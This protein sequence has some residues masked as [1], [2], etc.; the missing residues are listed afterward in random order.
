VGGTLKAVAEDLA[1][2]RGEIFIENSSQRESFGRP[3]A[4]AG[5]ELRRTERARAAAS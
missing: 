4:F 3:G 1:E 2:R 5:K